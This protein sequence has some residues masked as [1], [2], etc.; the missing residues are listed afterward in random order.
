MLTFNRITV[1]GDR[2]AY[3]VRLTAKGRTLFA[4]M[5]HQH[6]SWIVQAFSSLK[7]TDIATLYQLLGQ[8]KQHSL[9]DST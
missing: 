8:V 2:R 4:Q 9:K 1:D 5:A 7:D 6:E 3:R